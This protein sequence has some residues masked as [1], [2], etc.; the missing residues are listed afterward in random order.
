MLMLDSQAVVELCISQGFAIAGVS[1]AGRSSHDVALMQWL[2]AEKHGEMQWMNEN[3]EIRL[4]PR[5]LIEGAKT[6]ICVADRYGILA[7]NSLGERSGR[8]ARYA[9]G[10]DYHK[11]MKKRLH[12]ICDALKKDFPKE[13][14]R[15]CVDTAP[16]LERE[17]A[18]RSGIGAIGKH[19][20][21]I[22]QGIG[23]WMLLGAIVTTAPCQTSTRVVVDPCATCT[24]CIDA[25][26][27]DAISPW[28]LDARKCISYLTIEH[29]GDIDPLYYPKIGRWLFGCDICQEVCPHNQPSELSENAPL[30]PSYKQRLDSF[31][32]LDVLAWDEE[33]RRDNFQ[34]SS[35]K[36]AKLGMIRRNAVIVAGNILA[37][38]DDDVLRSALEKIASNSEEDA[39]VQRAALVVLSSVVK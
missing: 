39:L 17:F 32:V 29:R 9:R 13:I 33:S 35:M 8:I 22:E 11:T 27:T 34:G 20:L 4:D 15:A 18:Q 30:H 1:Q 23:S 26:P 28:A 19:T 38:S 21:L 5:N 36:R 16:L 14:F 10:R 7:E 12:V 6:V 37:E 3:I 2:A 25:C 31:D 24:R